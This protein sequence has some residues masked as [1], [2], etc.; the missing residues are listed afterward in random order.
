VVFCLRVKN[1]ILP[2][3]LSE[4]RHFPCIEALWTST[5]LHGFPMPTVMRRLTKFIGSIAL[6]CAGLYVLYEELLVRYSGI[7]GRY[8]PFWVGLVLFGSGAFQLWFEF[9]G[10]IV[11]K[12]IL[13][14]RPDPSPTGP[15]GRQRTIF[16]AVGKAP[17][18]TRRSPHQ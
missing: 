16:I 7:H 14:R 11:L 5:S 8:G 18:G 12:K 13:E 15:G 9:L 6:I 17:A 2:I 4:A 1:R 10:P 3:W